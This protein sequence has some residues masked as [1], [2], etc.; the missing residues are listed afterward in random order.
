M[1]ARIDVVNRVLR[2]Q[3]SGVRVVRAFVREPL[4]T[5]RFADANQEL[6]DTA[7]RAGRLMALMFPTVML[8][9]NASSVAVLWFGARRVNNG[10]HRDRR[11]DRLSQL[12]DADPVLG[13]DGDVHG[14]DGA[15]GIGQRG[16]DHRGAEHRILRRAAGKA[17]RA[18]HQHRRGRAW[19]AVEF[20]YPGA[21]EP[22]LRDIT[23][24]ARPGTTTAIIGSTGAGKTTLLS[25]IP[26]LFDAT[27]GSVTVDG[28]DVRDY[29]PENPLGP[30]RSGAAE[31]V[32]VHRDGRVEPAVRQPGRHRRGTLDRADHRAGTGIS[33]PPC[34]TAS[35]RPS[36]RAD[37]TCPAASGS[38]WRSPEPWSRNRTSTC[39]TTR[40][41]RW[42]WPPTPGCGRRCDPTTRDKTVIIVAQRVSTIADADQIVVLEDGRVVGVGR[43]DELIETCSTF[44]EIVQ[45]Q[46][47]AE[48]PA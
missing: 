45:S 40:S 44:I 7:V 5:R 29:D 33:S 37:R 47:A 3:I 8:V 4:E 27:A 31:A 36:R 6:T 14:R 16:P 15:K 41:P 34:R 22:V 19:T 48:V 12:P 28:V 46:L 26:R 1:Q 10:R 23:L 43:Y 30:H 20:S 35:T 13:D 21:S 38:G 39:S 11:P 25:L 32:P 17:D 18:G 24:R 2:E 9:L 42:T